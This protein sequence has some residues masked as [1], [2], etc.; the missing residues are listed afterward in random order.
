[1][2]LNTPLHTH[3]NPIF[4]FGTLLP[5]FPRN[6][7]LKNF[8]MGKRGSSSGSVPI[9]GFTKLVIESRNKGLTVEEIVDDLRSKNRECV[10][11]RRQ[12]LMIK[13]KQII[14]S[15]SEEEDDEIEGSRKKQRR[16]DSEQRNS[17]LCISASSPHSSASSP[18]YV[19]TSDDNMQFDI[20]NDGLRVSYSN[21]SKTPYAFNFPTETMKIQAMSSEDG[22][23]GCDVEVKGPTF[24]D[25]GGLKGVLDELMFDV[26]LPF[27]CPDVT[28]A[29]CM[30][31]ISGLLLYGPS[32]C[33]KST[34]AY[35]IANETGV[36]FYMRSA[37]ELVSGVS[38]MIA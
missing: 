24:K 9:R 37:S 31:P 34:L 18:G 7:S 26:K 28:Q 2:N 35:A 1:R 21:K 8:E 14:N 27:L 6:P 23:K 32:G 3:H 4:V 30:Q 12:I 25:L 22:S 10:R 36:P 33:G 29:I 15:L 20:T 13:V 19:L 17:D 16:D 38:G 11:L 5:L